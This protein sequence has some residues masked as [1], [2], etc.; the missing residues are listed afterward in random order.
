MKSP[1]MKRVRFKGTI[2]ILKIGLP[3]RIAI[4]ILKMEQFGFTIQ[5][6]GVQKI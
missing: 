3:Q 5:T 1:L 2:K 6:K 4:I